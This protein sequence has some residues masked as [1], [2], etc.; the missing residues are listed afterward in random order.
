MQGHVPE[1]EPGPE[2]APGSGA[3]SDDEHAGIASLTAAQL[4]QLYS[5]MELGPRRR[6]A[7]WCVPALPN[8]VPAPRGLDRRAAPRASCAGS[9]CG[10]S[11]NTPLRPQVPRAAQ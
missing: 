3:S 2:P 11:L 1:P 5:K 7:E 10:S 8:L 6:L 4:Y 9:K